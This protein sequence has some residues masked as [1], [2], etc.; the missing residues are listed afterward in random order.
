M[1]QLQM[2]LEFDGGFDPSNIK[3]ENVRNRQIGRNS[4]RG[5]IIHMFDLLSLRV[6]ILEPKLGTLDGKYMKIQSSFW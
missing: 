2:R 4:L 3:W 1:L 6:S 5:E